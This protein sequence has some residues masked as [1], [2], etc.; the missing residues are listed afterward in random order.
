MVF[1]LSLLLSLWAY[2]LK[3]VLFSP[4]VMVHGGVLFFW[5]EIVATADS[6][7]LMKWCSFS[8]EHGAA[9]FR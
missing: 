1:H 5:I 3:I 9:V 6:K 2:K 7:C 4:E 8:S